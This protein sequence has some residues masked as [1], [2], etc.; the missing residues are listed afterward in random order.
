[1]GAQ[2]RTP[3]GAIFS[4]AV[5]LP[6]TLVLCLGFLGGHLLSPV[7]GP[8]RSAELVPPPSR[9]ALEL[10]WA[11]RVVCPA[12][13]IEPPAWETGDPW[14]R[15]G[16]AAAG[17]SAGF[18]LGAFAG[19]IAGVASTLFCCWLR[20]FVRRH[21]VHGEAARIHPH[22]AIRADQVKW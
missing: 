2:L 11:R 18:L 1:M 5:G 15:A 4:T 6:A 3:A 10:E 13:P 21:G 16:L 9:E 20:P 7:Q 22:L 19:V 8:A 14:P 12:C 17:F